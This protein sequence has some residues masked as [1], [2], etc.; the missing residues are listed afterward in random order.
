MYDTA[1]H[2][3][4]LVERYF[5]LEIFFEPPVRILNYDWLEEIGLRERVCRIVTS[6]E[7]QE[8]DFPTAQCQLHEVVC[9]FMQGS[10]HP[11]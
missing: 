8:I 9:A 3:S 1:V 11:V 2:L 7:R 5:S 6:C 4:E 10:Q